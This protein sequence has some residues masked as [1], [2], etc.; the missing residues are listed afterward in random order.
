MAGLVL[1]TVVRRTIPFHVLGVAQTQHN[2]I[3]GI[4][5][6]GYMQ[7]CN[8]QQNTN[9]ELPWTLWYVY[10]YQSGSLQVAVQHISASMHSASDSWNNKAQQKASATEVSQSVMQMVATPQHVAHSSFDSVT[11]DTSSTA[12][13]APVPRVSSTSPVA[14]VTETGLLPECLVDDALPP[15]APTGTEQQLAAAEA[16]HMQDAQACTD[17]SDRH[18][19]HQIPLVLPDHCGLSEQPAGF[20]LVCNSSKA[21]SSTGSLSDLSEHEQAGNECLQE[22]LRHS[23]DG[24]S[25]VRTWSDPADDTVYGQQAIANTFS[26]NWDSIQSDDNSPTAVSS[27]V[28]TAAAHTS[29]LS[30]LEAAAADI[31]NA[32]VWVPSTVSSTPGCVTAGPQ[33]VWQQ[34]QQYQHAATA[35]DSCQ[36]STAAALIHF[37][38]NMRPTRAIGKHAPGKYSWN[39]LSTA[40]IRCH[41]FAIS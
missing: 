7:S 10:R 6:L 15:K 12:A 34:Q 37:G 40:V 16:V 20:I 30:F 9:H 4:E 5:Y 3:L 33:Q 28:T 14:C 38:S 23:S 27:P 25:S 1:A 36:H 18:H 35:G 2:N 19:T 32:A 41:A 39:S 17:P 13:A 21:L 22:V 29:D 26:I 11:S 24:S 31:G 8:E